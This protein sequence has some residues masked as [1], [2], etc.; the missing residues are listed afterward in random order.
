MLTQALLD[1]MTMVESRNATTNAVVGVSLQFA[2][3]LH[4]PVGSIFLMHV[5]IADISAADFIIG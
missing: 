5:G 4:H 3:T 2:D 1:S